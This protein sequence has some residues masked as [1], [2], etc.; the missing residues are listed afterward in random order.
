MG[1]IADDHAD[2]YYDLHWDDFVQD[3]P[4]YITYC[5]TCGVSIYIERGSTFTSV[6]KECVLKEHDAVAELIKDFLE[7][8]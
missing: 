4:H 3:I 7:N 6:C 5:I 2:R 8:G 1:E